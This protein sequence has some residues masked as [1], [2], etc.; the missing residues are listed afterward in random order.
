VTSSIVKF[1]ENLFSVEQL[2]YKNGIINNR[3]PLR[4]FRFVLYSSLTLEYTYESPQSKFHLLVHEEKGKEFYF[5][6]F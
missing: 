6:I 2:E 5:I 3:E 4:L 1:I